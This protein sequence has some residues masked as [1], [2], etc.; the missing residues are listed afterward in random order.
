MSYGH[1]KF[2]SFHIFCFF[3]R[4][5][6]KFLQYLQES[7]LLTWYLRIKRHSWNKDTYNCIVFVV[8][9]EGSLSKFRFCPLKFGDFSYL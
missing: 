7:A 3:P 9:N 5:E 1:F 2:Q 6:K 8:F 4:K